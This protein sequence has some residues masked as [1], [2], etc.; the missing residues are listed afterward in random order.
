MKPAGSFSKRAATSPIG[1]GSEERTAWGRHQ[2]P[3][4]ASIMAADCEQRRVTDLSRRC[5]LLFP[6]LRGG[7]DPDGRSRR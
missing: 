7:G 6:Q 5:D 1:D 2:L 4:L 3:A